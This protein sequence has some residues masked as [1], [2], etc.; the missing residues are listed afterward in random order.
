[1]QYREFME[2]ERKYIPIS[3]REKEYVFFMLGKCIEIN[4][5]IQGHDMKTSVIH[6]FSND[7]V[8]DVN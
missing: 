1:M 3:S 5:L 8:D 6:V 4:V 2:T 7:L